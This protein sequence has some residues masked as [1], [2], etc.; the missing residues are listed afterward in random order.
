MSETV[1]SRQSPV[2]SRRVK[3]CCI[4]GE[5]LFD[6]FQN[7]E[8]NFPR[9]RVS[10]GFPLDAK[11]INVKHGWVHLVELLVASPEFD[12]VPDGQVIP[13]FTPVVEH[14]S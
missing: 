4:T 3:R 1:A 7:G 5:L 6:L 10:N 13:E 11:L 9:Y 2:A 8:H 12:E 14:I